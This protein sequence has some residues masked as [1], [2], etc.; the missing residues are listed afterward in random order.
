MRHQ[1]RERSRAIAV[2]LGKWCV[3]MALAV[4]VLVAVQIV[5]AWISGSVHAVG[6]LHGINALVIFAYTGYLT[7]EAHRGALK[8]WRGSADP[9]GHG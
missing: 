3:L 5:L 8:A 2:R 9:V 6:I 4:P 7:G 1:H